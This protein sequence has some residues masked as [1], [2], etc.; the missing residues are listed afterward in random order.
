MEQLLI[1]PLTIGLSVGLSFLLT[2]GINSL[3]PLSPDYSFV[4]LSVSLLLFGLLGLIS[5]KEAGDLY[6]DQKKMRHICIRI[7]STYGVHIE[8]NWFGDMLS[9]VLWSFSSYL[10]KTPIYVIGIIIIW[11]VGLALAGATYGISIFVAIMVGNKIIEGLYFLADIFILGFFARSY[12]YLYR[13]LEDAP[14]N[15][16][17]LR[18]LQS[19]LGRNFIEDDHGYPE[20]DDYYGDYPDDDELYPPKKYRKGRKRRR[21][22]YQ[23]KK[24]FTPL[25]L[26]NP[27]FYLKWLVKAIV[28]I[29]KF[30]FF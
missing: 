12:M 17:I 6:E 27:F 7:Y 18:K 28:K 29:F 10:T 14:F 26:L 4:L 20:D 24:E 23:Y 25:S 8:G 16:D 9:S 19:R 30:L 15:I 11:G 2:V 21:T 5:L 1:F 13:N 3:F 22:K